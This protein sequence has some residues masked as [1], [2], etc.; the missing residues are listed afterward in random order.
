MADWFPFLFFGC[1]GLGIVTL[2]T[3]MVFRH[4]EEMAALKNGHRA[5]A[6]MWGIP[7]EEAIT[8]YQRRLVEAFRD[9][10]LDCSMWHEDALKELA[11]IA[12]AALESAP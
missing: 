6:G 7:D 9:C 12:V 11:D 4:R 8:A 10:E 3:D 2:L 5:I 1:I